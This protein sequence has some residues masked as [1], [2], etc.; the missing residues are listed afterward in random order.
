M[1][2]AVAAPMSQSCWMMTQIKRLFR[3]NDVKKQHLLHRYTKMQQQFSV[4]TGMALLAS[5][6]D[7]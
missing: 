4:I 6:M 7:L 1:R 2:G 5:D 3:I